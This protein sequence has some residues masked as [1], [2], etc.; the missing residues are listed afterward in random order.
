MCHLRLLV[1]QVIPP[2]FRDFVQ[3]PVKDPK[4]DFLTVRRRSLAPTPT[5][6]L[7]HH[8]V[9]FKRKALMHLTQSGQLNDNVHWVGD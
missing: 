3:M 5:E 8:H 6:I 1:N 9:A 7:N 4:V 2:E